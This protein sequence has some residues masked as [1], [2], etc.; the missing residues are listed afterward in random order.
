MLFRSDALKGKAAVANARVAYELYQEK[1]KGF[2][3]NHQRP[4]WAST[5]VKDPAYRNTLYVDSLIAP[6]TVNTMPPA[7]LDATIAAEV[8]AQDTITKNIE[9]AKAELLALATAGIDLVKVT[10]E[11][12]AD[13]VEKFMAS[14]EVLLAEVEKAKQ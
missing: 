10:D 4:L 6:N 9:S 12:E 7:T 14:W 1:F 5:G 13:G 11:L 8:N 2:A 3:H